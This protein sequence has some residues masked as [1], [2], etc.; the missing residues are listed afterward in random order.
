MFGLNSME[1]GDDLH[2]YR[3]KIGGTQGGYARTS[4]GL[5]AGIVAGTLIATAMGWRPV[6]ALAEGDLVLTFDAGLQ[7]VRSVRRG[8]HWRDVETCPR[9]LWPLNVP[10]DA[11]GNKVEMQILP[12]QFVL[13]ESDTADLLMDDPFMLISAGALDGYRGITA[14]APRAEIS[15]VQLTFDEDEVVFAASGALMCCP[16]DIRV[17]ISDLVAD[18]AGPARYRALSGEEAGLLVDCLREED[19]TREARAQIGDPARKAVYAA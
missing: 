14:S 5:A 6:E 16:C 17:D 4:D 11:L 12:E 9:A 13:V 3:H 10:V 19:E 7:P 15:V 8:T 2:T 18:D 1:S